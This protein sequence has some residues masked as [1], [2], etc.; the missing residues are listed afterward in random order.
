MREDSRRHSTIKVSLVIKITPVKL[1]SGT[2]WGRASI[3]EGPSDDRRLTRR[4]RERS[5][6]QRCMLAGCCVLSLRPSPAP[7]PM[8]NEM[9]TMVD[10]SFC[11]IN[12]RLD[13]LL[14]YVLQSSEFIRAYQQQA[15]KL[16]LYYVLDW[17][18][19]AIMLCSH[20]S[21]RERD[22]LVMSVH[23]RGRGRHATH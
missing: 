3:T 6:N 19:I 10:G 23:R 14:Y 1:D 22:A 13:I 7:T 18:K 21:C 8:R 9:S 20:A 12:F 15:T 16:A 17:N 4:F 2:R 5:R 11:F